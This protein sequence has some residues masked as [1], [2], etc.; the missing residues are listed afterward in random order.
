MSRFVFLAL[1]VCSSCSS[2]TPTGA[3]CPDPDPGTLT[4]ESFGQPFMEKYCN[5]CHDSSLTR[6]KRNGAPLYHDFNTLEFVLRFPE[7]I[8]Q[9][10]GFG[11]NAR[12]EFMPPDECPSTKGGALNKDCLQ[13]TDDERRQLAEWLACEKQREHFFDAGVDALMPPTAQ[14]PCDLL[15]PGFGQ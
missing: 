4:W 8:D 12:N 1:I 3:T 13:P 10:A 2:P 11:P 15:P 14:L 9:E 6:S 7:H 5:W